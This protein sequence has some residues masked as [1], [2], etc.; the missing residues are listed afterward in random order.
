M[1]CIHLSVDC[2]HLTLQTKALMENLVTPCLSLLR[3]G[4]F[5][6]DNPQS[7]MFSILWI[8]R[9]KLQLKHPSGSRRQVHVRSKLTIIIGGVP[10]NTNPTLYT[11]QM[12]KGKD[13]DRTTYHPGPN[14]STDRCLLN[15]LTAKQRKDLCMALITST[16]P[17]DSFG[18]LLRSWERIHSPHCSN[19][20]WYYLNSEPPKLFPYLSCQL[21]V[22]LELLL[23][24]STMMAVSSK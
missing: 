4:V 17:F 19:Y 22:L 2:I 14:P 18:M 20:H 1:D 16:A 23:P 21:L 15:I 9:Q 7:V 12:S 11:F 3:Q 13:R 5:G 8:C 24:S 6:L 10:P